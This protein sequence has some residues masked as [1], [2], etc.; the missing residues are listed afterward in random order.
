MKVK[1]VKFNWRQVGSIMTNDGAGEDW[2]IVTVGENG[3]V[4]IIENEPCNGMQLW[5]FVVLYKDKT[6]A[7]IFNPNT[8]IYFPN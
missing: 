2:E 3:V 5:N 6:T 7:R 4:G 8:V 1:S